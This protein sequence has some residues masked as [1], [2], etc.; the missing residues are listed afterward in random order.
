M[1]IAILTALIESLSSD[2]LSFSKSELRVSFE[3][4]DKG[5]RARG[6]RFVWWAAAV[7]IFAAGGI[8]AL[9][10][11]L[12]FHWTARQVIATVAVALIP[13]IIVALLGY[14]TYRFAFAEF[15]SQAVLDAERKR[16]EEQEKLAED[17]ALPSLL[18]YNREQMS[19]YH[20]IATTQARAAG[21]NSQTA[22]TIGFLALIAG[23]I[24][25]ITS[26]DVATKFVTGGLAALGGIFSGYIARTFLVAQERAIGQLY[27]Y[28]EQPLT[29]SY[30][31]MAER[32]TYSDAFIDDDKKQEELRKIIDHLLVIAARHESA[33]VRS[34]GGKPGKRLRPKK[35][36]AHRTA[37]SSSEESS[38]P[39]A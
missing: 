33:S 26:P 25:A 29:T 6:R 38:R 8:V 7:S 11:G 37:P 16:A 36:K 13:A 2:I 22:M 31:L 15:S 27:N 5:I 30:V 34:N 9:L 1:D 10:G 32:I 24:V 19:L 35:S 20:R 14:A 12:L 21:R 18:R 23:T 39:L 4:S 28:W 17:T 3:Q